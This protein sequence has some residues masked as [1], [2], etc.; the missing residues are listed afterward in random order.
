[1]LQEEKL[2]NL[3]KVWCLLSNLFFVLKVK[4]III[5]FTSHLLCNM[6]MAFILECAI[7][8]Q[9]EQERCRE[10]EARVRELE[11]QVS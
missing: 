2:L 8:L 9:L 5:Y 1:M 11:K 6:F 3:D 10:A 7:Q 4:L